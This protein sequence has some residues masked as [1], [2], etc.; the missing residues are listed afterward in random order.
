MIIAIDFD[1]TI[2]RDAYPSIGELNPDAAIVIRSLKDDGHYLIINTCRSG[3]QAIHAIN[4]LKEK[5]IPFDRINDNE[6][7]HV[8]E[9]SNNCRKIY[10]DVYIDDRQ[11]GGLPL[12]SEIYDSIT[13][14][15][16][17]RQEE[18]SQTN[19]KTVE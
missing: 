6:P 12:W 14:L 16:K 4:F 19:K 7:S 9:Y 18:I 15:D 5:A 17:Q 8:A 10:A 11:V 1:G 2:C 3:D 13:K